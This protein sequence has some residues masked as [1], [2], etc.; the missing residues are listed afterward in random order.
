MS[1]G[2]AAAPSGAQINRWIAETRP[3]S[4]LN[5]LGEFIASE[6]ARVEAAGGPPARQL[7]PLLMTIFLQESELGTTGYLS[8]HNNFSGLTGTGWEGQTGTVS[9][10]REFA[11]FASPEAGIRAT[12]ANL[13]TPRYVGRSV[14]EQLSMWLTGS[15][16]GGGDEEGNTVDAYLRTAG[17]VF[18]AFGQQVDGIVGGSPVGQP[19][20]IPGLPGVPGLPSQQD[21]EA[22]LKTLVIV[23]IAAMLVVIGAYALATDQ[24]VNLRTYIQ[25]QKD[26][27]KL[28]KDITTDLA[29][30]VLT[31]ATGGAGAA[32]KAGG[33]AA[34]AGAAA[35]RAAT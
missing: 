13:T 29:G 12:I 17:A 3:G 25:M 18:R 33:K 23:G 5:G 31:V 26:G 4:P 19:V 10:A 1:I 34:S 20:G 22:A 11:A 9:G 15:Y 16:E 7:V 21:A 27:I 35:A 28:G 8:P 24:P 2:A 6:A 30:K 14:R 32:A